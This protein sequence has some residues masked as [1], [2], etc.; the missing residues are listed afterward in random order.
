M[1]EGTELHIVRDD[2]P[3]CV[4]HWVL[5]DPAEGAVTG[6]CKRCGGERA[7]S[8]QVEADDRFDRQEPEPIVPADDYL[9]A[10]KVG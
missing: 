8:A 6:R 2:M 7:F 1:G 3:S 10:W 9:T 5:S 4:H